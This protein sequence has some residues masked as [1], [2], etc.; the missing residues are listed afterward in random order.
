MKIMKFSSFILC[1]AILATACNS[2]APATET[3]ATPTTVD[4][5]MVT[6]Q[7][8]LP[9]ADTQQV[10]TT[11]AAEPAK[12][13][14]T[15]SKKTNNSHTNTT[16]NSGSGESTADNAGSGST[17]TAPADGGTTAST[18]GAQEEKKGWSKTAKGAVI[19][20]VTGA[21]AGAVINKKNRGVGAVIGGVTGAAAGAV[22]GKQMDKKDGRSQ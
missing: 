19:G 17:T 6:I 12:K 18:E 22:I 5:G 20:G 1:A 4:T 8:E 3:T 7:P 10:E 14:A 9:V 15:T 11:P 2:N 16:S 21:A 13:S